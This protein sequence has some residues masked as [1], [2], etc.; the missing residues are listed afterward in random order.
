[1][2][3]LVVSHVEPPAIPPATSTSAEPSILALPVL[4]A[5]FA[6]WRAAGVYDENN[7]A[8]KS[9]RQELTAAL[10]AVF[11]T[12]ADC[13]IT[14]QNDY[15]FFN[16]QRLNYDREFS[17]GRSLAGRFTDL[18]LG[19]ITISVNTPPG[20]L[21]QALLALASC[22]VRAERP[23]ELL[24]ET[25]AKLGLTGVTMTPLAPKTSERLAMEQPGDTDPVVLRKRRAHALFHRAE[26]VVQEYWE[27]VRDR[28]S[29]DASATRRIVHQL[30]DTI[31]NDEEMLLEFTTLKEFDDYTYYHSVN[32]AIYSIAVGMR[33]GL[34]RVRLT[35]LG[36]AALFHDIGKVKLPQE[37]IR[38]PEEFDE[39]DWAQIKR[40]PTLGA[41]TLASMRHIDAQIGTA[42]AGAFEHHLRMDGSGYPTLS[43]PRELHLYSRI[44]MLCDVFDA[45]TAGRVYQK[46]PT[47]P[48]EAMK[49]IVYKGRQWYDP[50]ILKAFIN[51]LGIFP[52]GTLARLSDGAVAVVTHNV[53]DD[54]FAP[55]VLIIRD[56]DGNP[57]RSHL[58]LKAR[59]TTAAE[60]TIHI[61]EILDPK[62]EGINIHDY[63]AVNYRSEDRPERATIS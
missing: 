44:I 11:A 22:D 23:Y 46:V 12:G 24:A 40:H 21:D 37:L 8:Y 6:A 60:E 39:N 49:R 7:N 16:G 25:W 28:N 13:V 41:L 32:V 18:Q 2:M 10:A 53:P 35:Q 43:R 58:R 9:R 5:L 56:R 4:K 34:G 15:F 62:V 54:P 3:R 1:M 52:V 26:S 31:A 36:M 51:V 59:E 47:P 48:D 63:I 61:A 27:H 50:L 45:M 29:F 19:G 57:I 14:Y 17:F 33:L 38:K 42:M 55:E 30:I 20:D